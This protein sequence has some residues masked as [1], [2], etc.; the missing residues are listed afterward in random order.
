VARNAKYEYARVQISRGALVPSRVF[1]DSAAWTGI[2]GNVRLLETQGSFSDGRYALASHAQ[3][4]APRKPADG[5]HVTTLSRLSENEYR[6]DTTVD[7]AIGSVRPG[8]AA[9]LVTRLIAS[10]ERQSEHEARADL[11]SVAPRTATALGSAFSLDSLHPTP[12]ADGSTAVTAVIAMRSELLARRYP[13]FGAY[14]RKYIDPARYRI[15][16]ADRSGVPFI[17]AVAKDRLLTLRVR[18]L[19]GELVPLVGAARPM[20]DT[21]SVL[22]DFKVKIKHLTVGFHSLSMEL[23]HLRRDDVENEWVVTARKEPEW[24][25][26]FASAHLIRAPLRRPFAGEGSLFRIGVRADPGSPTVIVRQG[27][28]FVQE[29]AILRMLNSLGNTAMDDFESQVERE[30]NAWLRE[31]FFAMREDARAAIAP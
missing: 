23:I 8:E 2:S 14:M 28:I 18:T 19:R 17:E 30:E 1:Q 26:P 7:F 21:L 3:V 31:L 9:M 20:P 12:L 29:S 10:A 5:R 22:A 25:M 15:V 13:A 4:P 24:D 6:W 11:Q 27:R 16:L